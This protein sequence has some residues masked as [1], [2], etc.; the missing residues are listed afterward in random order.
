MTLPPTLRPTDP[1]YA[2]ERY[3]LSQAAAYLDIGADQLYREVA[4]GR[5]GFRRNGEKGR[6]HFSQQDLDEWRQAHRSAARG[7]ARARL[8]VPPPATPLKPLQLPKVRRFS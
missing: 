6:I 3:G 4:R 1:D 2:R 8:P 5:I 7:P